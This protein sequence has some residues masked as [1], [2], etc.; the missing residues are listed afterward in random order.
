MTKLRKRFAAN[1]ALVRL[2]T[3]VNAEMFVQCAVFRETFA[4]DR[5][6]IWLLPCMNP[7][8]ALEEEFLRKTFFADIT[9]ESLFNIQIHCF[10]LPKLLTK[11][12][13]VSFKDGPIVD[14]FWSAFLIF[15]LEK[16]SREKKIIAL[17]KL[18][19]W[20]QLNAGFVF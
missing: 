4:A 16:T 18:F 19:L 20:L 15:T 6:R 10:F 2:L 14:I 8:V 3:G 1:V 13:N 11:I 9:F 12:Q 7:H 17:S 5:T